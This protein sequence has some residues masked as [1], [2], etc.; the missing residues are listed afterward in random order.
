MIYG[1][2]ITRLREIEILVGEEKGKLDLPSDNYSNL[3][4]PH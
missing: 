3:F 2:A 4:P 1:N